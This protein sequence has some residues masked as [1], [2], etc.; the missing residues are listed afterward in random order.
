VPE[1]EAKQAV[2]LLA[3]LEKEVNQVRSELSAADAGSAEL[4]NKLGMGSRAALDM[5]ALSQSAGV[6]QAL[7]ELQAIETELARRQTVYQDSHPIIVDLKDKQA[8]LR[9]VLGQRIGTV[10]NTQQSSVPRNLQAGEI[11]SQ[12]TSNL[13]QSEVERLALTSRLNNLLQTQANYQQQMRVLP[14]LEQVG[15]NLEREREIAQETY[16]TLVARLQ[17]ARVQEAKIAADNQSLNQA[18]ILE[19]AIIPENP[20]S[21]RNL[22]LALGVLLGGALAGATT[23]I[24]ELIDPSIKT[25]E[26]AREKWG[27]AVLGTIPA[28]E[29][30][31]KP[32]QGY[33]LGPIPENLPVRD[34]PRSLSSEAYRK[35]QVNLEFLDSGRP[36]QVIVVTSAVPKEGKS[37]VSANLAMTMA[38]RGHRVLLVD[39]D[40]RC[41]TQHQIWRLPNQIGLSDFVAGNVSCADAVQRLTENL[42]IL[43]S[44]P[45]PENPS[46]FLDSDRLSVLTEEIATHYDCVILDTAPLAVAADALILGKL[47]DGLLV[48]VQP[49]VV[50][51]MNAA[52]AKESLEQS[53]QKV[54]GLVINGVEPEQ[55]YSQ[56]YQD[57]E[58]NGG[59]MRSV[60][61]KLAAGVKQLKNRL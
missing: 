29:G 43:T 15:R 18:R 25:A 23:L 7:E 47:A 21:R 54:L 13:V 31:K 55:E 50:K 53:N 40:L 42:D 16:V 2:T 11:Q 17:E 37:T 22:Y 60:P 52:A 56:Y 10:I 12:L 14:Q 19:A 28:L 27:Y 49:G 61:Q 5:S 3:D 4:R 34:A 20:T 44:G 41:P 36:L 51:S 48:V 39:A 8:S 30:A 9:S 26:E 46:S 1:E 24:L 57:Y 33:S 35:L 45:L 58:Q 32:K 6:Q 59:G 38:Q